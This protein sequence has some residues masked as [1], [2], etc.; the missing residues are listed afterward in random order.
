[1]SEL[2]QDLPK[3]PLNR[4]KPENRWTRILRD[5]D[6]DQHE[7]L[8]RWLKF[9]KKVFEKDPEDDDSPTKAA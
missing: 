4:R 2:E 6:S 5:A 9:A 1:M 7:P 8:R 3:N